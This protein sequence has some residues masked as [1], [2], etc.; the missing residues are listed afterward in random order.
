VK[1][2]VTGVIAIIFSAACAEE[3]TE[4]NPPVVI[5]PGVDSVVV[6]P[7]SA[8][9]EPANTFQ[10]SMEVYVVGNAS[11]E[12][13]WAVIC[14][15][16]GG[17]ISSSG[18]FTAPNK[19]TRCS[20]KVTSAADPTKA[21]T[22]NVTVEREDLI[23]FVRSLPADDCGDQTDIFLMRPDG[24]NA[25]NL[26][27][28]STDSA[29]CVI[30]EEHPN[31]SPDNMKLVYSSN[32]GGK[33][34]IYTRRFDNK[35]DITNLTNDY[36]QRS[37]D[38]SWS[39]DSS[40]IVFSFVDSTADDNTAG[41]ALMNSNGANITKLISVPC[42]D[43]CSPPREPDWSPDGTRIVF[44]NSDDNVYTM[45]PDGT[46]LVNL[47]NHPSK[48]GQPAWSPN[49]SKIAFASLRS[50]KWEIHVMSTD[51]SEAASLTAVLSR[52]LE[53]SWSPDGHRIAFTVSPESSTKDVY[54]MNS[55]GT[56]QRNITNTP[57]QHESHPAWRQ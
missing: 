52:S 54:V 6:S 3:L 19:E 12:A 57:N 17:R 25:K 21:G 48:N 49:G 2:F 11:K 29:T 56:D 50:G 18:F 31:W 32:M 20:V 37:F 28:T 34:N 26:T 44:V 51:G 7:S 47:T 38:P 45:N 8:T 35:G 30:D 41:L 27:N 5:E 4:P 24:S 33:T 43:R 42:A 55:N 14:N 9:L 23:A 16:G 46:D 39:P 36:F 22:A 1:R 40:Q 10:F 53:P 15:E 13:G